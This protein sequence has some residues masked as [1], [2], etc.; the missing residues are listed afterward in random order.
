[1]ITHAYMI[2]TDIFLYILFTHGGDIPKN[3]K[4]HP[5]RG[6]RSQMFKGKRLFVS[7]QNG[8]DAFVGKPACRFPQAR[9]IVKSIACLLYTSRCV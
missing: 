1:M 8:A 7:G 5:F 2:F 6:F 4:R 3:V 9:L